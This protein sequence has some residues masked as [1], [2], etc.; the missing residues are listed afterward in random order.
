MVNILEKSLN[1]GMH[2]ADNVERV[3]VTLYHVTRAMKTPG[4]DQSERREL[5]V[6]ALNYCADYLN[7][8]F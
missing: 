8:K 6:K 3:K 7:I 4:Y 2:N 1:S 5:D